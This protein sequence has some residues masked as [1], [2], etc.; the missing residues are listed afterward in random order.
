MAATVARQRNYRAEYERRQQRA[1]ERGF[2]DYY[3]QRTRDRPG[4]EKP[5]PE[6]LARRRGHRSRKDFLDSLREGDIILCD[7]TGVEFNRATGRYGV[8]WKT[9]IPA[10]GGEEREYSLRNQTRSSLRLT[11]EQEVERGVIFSPSPSLDQRRLLADEEVDG[12][13]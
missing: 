13:Y 6:E 3:E 4:G 10:A 12:G 9:V 11:I 2:R 5:A 1:R 7:I 8:I